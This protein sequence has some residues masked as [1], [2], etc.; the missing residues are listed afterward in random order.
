MPEPLVHF[1]IPFFLL[2]MSGLTVRKAALISLLAILPDFDVLFH[3]HRSFS[4]SVF[5]ILMLS[6]PAI[7]I[8]KKFYNERFSDSIIAALVLLSHPFMDTFTYFTPV[9]WPLFNKSVYIL[10]ELTTNMNDVLDLNLKLNV[11]FES[12][13]FR[14]TAN[15]DTPIFSS[16]GVAVSLVLLIGLVLKNLSIKSPSSRP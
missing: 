13:V 16:T 4:H 6:I 9:L 7:I 1:I 10:A 15:I 14:Q 12:I 2:I 8:T 5:F 3:I 11:Y